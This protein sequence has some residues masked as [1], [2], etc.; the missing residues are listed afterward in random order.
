M[1]LTKISEAF[2]LKFNAITKCY[3]IIILCCSLILKNPFIKEKEELLPKWS[4]GINCF[5]FFNFSCY[6][7]FY[8]RTFLPLQTFYE[9]LDV[10]MLTLTTVKCYGYFV[11]SQNLVQR[12]LNKANIC[13]S[14]PLIN[15]PQHST[16]TVDQ[17]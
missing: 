11:S 4:L 10:T 9:H 13:M 1:Y 3:H 2:L 17:L 5:L 8:L 16:F 6:F 7:T 15:N 14:G 12:N